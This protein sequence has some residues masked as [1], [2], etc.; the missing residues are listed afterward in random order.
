MSIQK[1]ALSIA[2]SAH[3]LLLLFFVLAPLFTPQIT[4]KKLVVHSVRL[5]SQAQPVQTP[6]PT[7]PEP[8]KPTQTIAEP[9]KPTKKTTQQLSKKPP[10]PKKKSNPTP[11]PKKTYNQKLIAQALQN[12]DR[13]ASTKK[14]SQPTMPTIALSTL[15]SEEPQ[16]SENIYIS[17]LIQRL[18][19]ALR[20]PESG[21]ASVSLTISR[22]GNV[23]SLTI[24]SCSSSHIRKIITNKLPG[25]HFA[26]FGQNFPGEK[27]HTFLLKLSNLS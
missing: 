20:L 19:L 6:T 2:C 17:D 13:A 7:V 22:S 21:E 24:N 14:T 15:P 1:N 5:I 10:T 11:Q 26:P 18:Q 25:L 27:E 4:P 8:Q 12:L 16:S 3:F 23:S 9:K